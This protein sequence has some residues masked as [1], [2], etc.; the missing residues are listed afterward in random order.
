MYI[1]DVTS[2]VQEYGVDGIMNTICDA[3][4]II[5]ENMRSGDIVWI[6]CRNYSGD[7]EFRTL[8][9]EIGEIIQNS[10]PLYLRDIIT[11]YRNLE[12]GDNFKNSYENILLFSK[13]KTEY[14][15][16]KDR[17]RIEPVYE[18]DEW[19]GH[20][21]NG[22]SAYR[23]RTTKRYNPS[24][25]DPGNIWLEEIRT[26]SEGKVLDRTKPFSRI[27]AIQRCIR[28]SSSEGGIVHTLW[29]DEEMM[30]IIEAEGRRVNE[31][32]EVIFN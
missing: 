15:F 4:T 1:V 11:I 12:S 9:M 24:G 32:S 5:Y 29:A 27:E 7:R 17:I 14:K 30:K 25:K 23:D 6:F 28:L 16:N 20:R 8:P 2:K 22:H 21:K 19:N 18:G 3:S 31:L 10:H 13:D 26:E